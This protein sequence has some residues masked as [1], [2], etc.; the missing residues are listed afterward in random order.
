MQKLVRK[1]TRMERRNTSTVK[2]TK[3][4]RGTV[5][6]GT[7]MEKVS[8]KN[9]VIL[10]T[11]MERMS[12]RNAVILGTGMVR[13]TRN[14]HVWAMCHLHQRGGISLDRESHNHPKFETLILLPDVE[15]PPHPDAGMERVTR[16]GHV[17]VI[18]HL[19]RGKGISPDR[20][21]YN[22]PD[23]KTLTLLQDTKSPPHPDIG[24]KRLR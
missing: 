12:T 19:H 7:E 24:M 18:S 11:G 21:R 6:L 17:W 3:S 23:A 1:K 10:G 5:I 4:T 9:T 15:T 14:G 16:N 20:E 8:T 13:V 2:N 22:H